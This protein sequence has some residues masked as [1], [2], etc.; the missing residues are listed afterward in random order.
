MREVLF[1][2]VLQAKS[3]RSTVIPLL[4][5]SVQN[6]KSVNNYKYLGIA[7][8]TELSDDK[9]I[10]RQMRYQYYAANK[11]RASFSCGVQMPLKCTFSFLSYV[12]VCITIMV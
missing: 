3:A 2:A 8:D 9:V 4:T 1:S 6:V 12:H 5:L 7:V 10:Q 11:L